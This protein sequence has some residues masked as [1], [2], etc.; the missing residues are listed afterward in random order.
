MSRSYFEQTPEQ[1]KLA[2]LGRAMMDYSEYYPNLKGLK[3]EQLAVLNEMSHLG[4]LLTQY[5]APFGTTAKSFSD[6]DRE[7]IHRF[8]NRG[9]KQIELAKAA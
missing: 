2:D 1:R 3:D 7:L 9:D 4:Y 5:G 6:S 8:M